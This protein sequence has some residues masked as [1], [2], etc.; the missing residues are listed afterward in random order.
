MEELRINDPSWEQIK[1]SIQE[2]FAEW[3]DEWKAAEESDIITPISFMDNGISPLTP[4]SLSYILDMCYENS[5][6]KAA[7]VFGD[8]N[9]FKS[10]ISEPIRRSYPQAYPL[11][12]GLPIRGEMRIKYSDDRA[13]IQIQ[14][15]NGSIIDAFIINPNSRGKQYNNIIYNEHDFD[16]LTI[17]QILLPMFRLYSNLSTEPDK[18]D[19]ATHLCDK[20][21]DQENEGNYDTNDE[22][23]K[24][25]KS[26]KVTDN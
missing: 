4:Y 21:Q 12:Y 20:S 19:S 22:L 13:T 1:M 3:K 6:Y 14:Y 10:C 16:R 18:S 2:K 24:Y 8:H 15:A 17:S 11:I 5:N 25:L 23:D 9:S 26:L 7:I